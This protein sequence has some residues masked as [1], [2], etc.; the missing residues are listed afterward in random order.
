MLGLDIRKFPSR[1]DWCIR[2]G[3]I[4]EDRCD[5]GV[6]NWETCRRYRVDV[7]VS[8]GLATLAELLRLNSSCPVVSAGFGVRK[9]ESIMTCLGGRP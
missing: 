5:T 8:S 7:I 3:E 9:S 4:C 2:L 6:V 1:A